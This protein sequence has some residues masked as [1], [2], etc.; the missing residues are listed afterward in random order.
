MPDAE[1]RY[2]W[3]RAHA[4]L[5]QLNQHVTTWNTAHQTLFT[6]LHTPLNNPLCVQSI[7]LATPGF[8]HVSKHVP[9]HWW[10]HLQSWRSPESCST[11]LGKCCCNWRTWSVLYWELLWEDKDYAIS[12]NVQDSY[13]Q[14]PLGD[15]VT[16][17]HLLQLFSKIT[18]SSPRSQAEKNLSCCL[19]SF[20]CRCLRLH[21]A[22]Y[23]C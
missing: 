20:K 14:K 22:T 12:I 10:S 21:L 9:N 19:K 5:I 18:S 13:G 6:L 2:L 7:T 23:A 15:H 16:P 8:R 1:E 11:L 4:H 3:V 17:F